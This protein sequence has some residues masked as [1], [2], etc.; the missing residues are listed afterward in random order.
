MKFQRELAQHVLVEII[1]LLE[2]HYE[3]IAHYKDIPLDPD[4]EV[5]MKMET[6]GF[7]RVYTART[8]E[9]KLIGYCIYFVK[10]NPHYKTSLQ[11]LQDVFFIDP[12]HRGFG[13]KLLIWTHKELKAEGVQLVCQHIKAAHDFGPM[14]ERLGYEFMDKI[15]VKRLDLE[16]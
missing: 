12:A 4:Y 14:L 9:G 13:A 1:P 11:A 10:T 15:Y 2:K 6:I 16:K 8:E 5:Y 3:E 7:L